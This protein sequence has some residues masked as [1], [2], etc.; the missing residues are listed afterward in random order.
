MEQPTTVAQAI[1]VQE[2]LRGLVE[3]VDVGTP[4]QY[5]AGLDVAYD[6]DRLAAAVVVLDGAT[7]AEVDRVVV[8]GETTFPYVPGL[9]AFREVPALLAALEQLGTTPEL[10][11]C[12]GQGL[13]H[14]RR[15]GLA[16]HLGVLT[17]IPAI[18]AAKTTF[19]GSHGELA[20]ER[21]ATAEL[22]DDGE[23]VGAAVRTQDGIKPIY[24]SVGHRVTLPTAVAQ[25]LRLA[26]RY[27][28]PETTRLADRACREELSRA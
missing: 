6:G 2:E 4:P 3:C 25:V 7:L 21:G 5:V 13:A 14:P 19:V 8:R 1:A 15:F 26:P 27:R 24:V 22:V 9:F 10:L 11:V 16:C 20:R 17:G 23:V 12:D 28:L 18:G